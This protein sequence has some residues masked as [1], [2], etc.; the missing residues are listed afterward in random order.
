MEITISNELGHVPV[1]VFHLS[2]NLS[3]EEPLNSKV[4]SHY[5]AGMR[6]ALLDLS[7]VDYIS[8]GGLRAIHSVFMMLRQND[9]GESDE[10][11]SDGIAR[12]TYMSPHLKLFQPSDIAAKSLHISGYDMFLEIHD[13]YYEAIASFH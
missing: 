1:T 3:E 7:S 8:S 11:I 6:Y 9:S 5:E 4:S 2:G 13:N 12:G 10:E